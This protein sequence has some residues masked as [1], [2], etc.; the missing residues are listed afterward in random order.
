MF[1]LSIQQRFQKKKAPQKNLL[2][3]CAHHTADTPSDSSEGLSCK[4]FTN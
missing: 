1:C 3:E 4:L 2:S